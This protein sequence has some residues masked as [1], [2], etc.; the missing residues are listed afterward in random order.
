MSNIYSK[1]H[2]DDVTLTRPVVGS[3]KKSTN[4]SVMMLTAMLTRLACPPETPRF[5]AFPMMVSL[6]IIRGTMVR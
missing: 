5:R 4:G 2:S 1:H 6:F 3:S